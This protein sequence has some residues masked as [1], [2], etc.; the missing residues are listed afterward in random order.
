MGEIHRLDLTFCALVLTLAGAASREGSCKLQALLSLA[1]S[2]SSWFTPAHHIGLGENHQHSSQLISLCADSV[3]GGP[4]VS[5]KNDISY[6][7]CI[8]CA[9]LLVDRIWR[10][11]TS[12]TWN[13]SHP[14]P[15][16][17]MIECNK[18]SAEIRPI[19]LQKKAVSQ[20]N[21][22]GFFQ[23]LHL[24]DEQEKNIENYHYSL[25]P[26]G[27]P[28]M[29]RTFLLFNSLHFGKTQKLGYN[30]VNPPLRKNAK[31]RL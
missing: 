1:P 3:C 19:P 10:Q 15:S 31:V 13:S 25:R 22:L 27:G 18:T 5:S 7:C 21:P 23:P 24:V 20:A 28:K 14:I 2:A 30:H 4:F 9:Q 12:H 29:Y 11:V 6:S 16:W 17:N 8:W 26:P